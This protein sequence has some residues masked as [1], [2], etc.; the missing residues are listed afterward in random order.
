[1]VHDLTGQHLLLSCRCCGVLGHCVGL[2]VSLLQCVITTLLMLCLCGLVQRRV[3][4]SWDCRGV[5]LVHYWCCICACN[6]DAV[7]EMQAYIFDSDRCYRLPTRCGRSGRGSVQQCYA[8]CG[9][10]SCTASPF[11][12]SSKSSGR[13]RSADL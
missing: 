5:W 11:D 13:S 9:Q 6:N 12:S 10:D 2:C 3:W 4:A 7:N 1:M 8:A